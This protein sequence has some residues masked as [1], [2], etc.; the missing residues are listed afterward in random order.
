MVKKQQGFVINSISVSMFIHTL[1]KILSM[2]AFYFC[3]NKLMHSD[4]IKLTKFGSSQK[5]KK[6]IVSAFNQKKRWYF[7]DLQNK[8]WYKNN[9]TS[10]KIANRNF[11]TTF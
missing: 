1:F 8:H 11:D 10:G 6:K 5:E 4:F 9:D 2:G 7:Q 3:K